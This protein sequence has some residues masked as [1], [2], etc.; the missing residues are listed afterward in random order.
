MTIDFC[1]AM[2]WQGGVENV[3][4]RTAKQLKERGYHVRIVQMIS[5]GIEWV[6]P[7][8]EYYCLNGWITEI[9]WDAMEGSYGAF[10][11][12]HGVGEVVFAVAWPAMA[13]IVKSALEKRGKKPFLIGWPHGTLSEYEKDG[14]GGAECYRIV[15]TAFAISEAIASD[16]QEA[17]PHTKVIRVMNPVLEEKIIFSDQRDTRKL[18]FV[19]RIS[20]EKNIPYL[21]RSLAAA[22]G[23]WTLS[24]L[25]DGE[26]EEMWSLAEELGISDRVRFAGWMENP[27]ESLKN[28][29]ALVMPSLHEGFSL[30]IIEA[31]ACGMTVLSTPVGGAMEV[32]KDG[33]NGYLFGGDT[34]FSLTE[35]LNRLQEG[36]DQ[37]ADP[38]CCA[39]SAEPYLERNAIP[40]F[41]Q[42]MEKVYEKSQRHSADV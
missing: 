32:I 12:E 38:K 24:I 17:C 33:A 34:G 27:W 36:K 14:V 42:K 39:A 10:V 1:I 13:L 28:T 7:E 20:K 41:I 19:G 22:E 30:T 37:F 18:A 16:L 8:I 26:I 11:D 15:D 21:L 2:G 31:L 4:N 23:D 9:D 6:D 3:L 25:G 35:R 5:R 40:D 29:C